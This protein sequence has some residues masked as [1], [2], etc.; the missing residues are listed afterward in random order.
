MRAAI[1]GAGSLGTILGAFI[2]RA[3]GSIDLINRN[4]AHIMALQSA[5]A[6]IVGTV[7][8]TQ[9]V[10]AYTVDEMSGR[11]DILFLL[12]KQQENAAVAARLKGF[13]AEDGVLVSLQNGIPELQ[14][15][16]ILGGDRVL[17][18][19]V[20]WGATMERP[21]VC[22]LTS[23]PDSLTFSLGSLS[24]TPNPRLG[25][26]KAL[27]EL[28]G[29]VTLDANFIGTR[30]SKLLI[31]SAFSGMSAVLGCTFGEAAKDWKSR[32]IVQALI[33]ECI[34]VCA[35][36]DIRIEP[37]QGKDI[38]KLLDYRGPLKKAFAFAIIPIAIRKHALLKASMLQ[39]LEKGK[40]TEVDA[41]NGVVSA[42]GRKVGCPTPMNDRVVELVHRMESGELRPSFDNLKYF[43]Q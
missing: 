37:V 18:C 31:N 12:T 20:A 27:L 28:M 17:G 32:R 41:I 14:L 13:L 23:A 3:G 34:D 30:W 2:T 36:G 33:K 15:G 1:Y 40:K 25:E 5:G 42:F 10:T 39:D 21:G 29:P 26:V 7:E 8:F 4:K 35:A 22:R 38:V 43:N 6:R 24:G 9:P 11:Y 16:E 19:T